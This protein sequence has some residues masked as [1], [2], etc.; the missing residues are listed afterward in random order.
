L[1]AK[2]AADHPAGKGDMFCFMANGSL[3]LHEYPADL[4]RLACEKCGRAGQY[5][6]PNLIERY[7]VDARLPDIR[8][9]IAKCSR[10]GQWHA[11]AEFVTSI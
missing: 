7:G 2:R 5:R 11:A 8:E 9:Q 1:S 6:K 10:Q 4:V 3:Q